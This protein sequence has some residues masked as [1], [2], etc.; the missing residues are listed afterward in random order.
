MLIP[1]RVDDGFNG[2][3]FSLLHG[4]EMINCDMHWHGSHP[5][6]VDAHRR[7]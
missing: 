7:L 5:A 3:L 6:S 1:L 4:D 2:L